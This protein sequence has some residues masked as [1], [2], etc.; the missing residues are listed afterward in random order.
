MQLQTR[1]S[2]TIAAQCTDLM[3]C[4]KT[5]HSQQPYVFDV[6]HV[7]LPLM[8]RRIKNDQTG[9]IASST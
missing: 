2:V 3:S 4:R 7:T 5:Q 9:T 1:F 6:F 8:A